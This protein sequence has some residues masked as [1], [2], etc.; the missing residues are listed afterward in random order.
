M[1]QIKIS[2]PKNDALLFI[3]SYYSRR[4]NELRSIGV[5]TKTELEF[6]M[7]QEQ[8][9]TKEEST[10]LFNTEN[11]NLAK[12]NKLKEFESKHLDNNFIEN[13]ILEVILGYRLIDGDYYEESGLESKPFNKEY[14]DLLVKKN[15]ILKT[16]CEY[17][18]EMERR[19]LLTYFCCSD[20]NGK[21][22]WKS[23]ED[24][25]NSQLSKELKTLTNAVTSFLSGMEQTILRK[26]ARHPMWRT[27]WI[28]AT[29]TGATLFNGNISEWDSNKLMLCYW[30]NFYDNIYSGYEI[31]EDFIVNDDEMLDNWLE[32]KS[33]ERGKAQADPNSDTMRGVFKVKVN[34]IQKKT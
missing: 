11:S 10:L 31:P 27:R 23:P 24:I 14:Y 29:K 28:S 12:Y 15:K 13:R 9:F 30:S 22:L 33:K 1:Q 8:F 25:L 21:K 3:N 6:W 5:L 19:Y 32:A 2:F 20:Y 4:F 18:I 16:S 7:E 26:I 17:I 34:P